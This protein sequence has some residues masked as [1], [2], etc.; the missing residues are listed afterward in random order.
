MISVAIYA[1]LKQAR[2]IKIFIY[3]DGIING[4]GD[5]QRAPAAAPNVLK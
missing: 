5:D 2:N 3:I 1:L 4:D